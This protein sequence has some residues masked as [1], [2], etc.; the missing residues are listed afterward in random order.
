MHWT[1]RLRTPSRCQ[2]CHQIAPCTAVWS[3]CQSR[4]GTRAPTPP[5]CCAVTKDLPIRLRHQSQPIRRTQSIPLPP[6]HE[7]RTESHHPQD[8]YGDGGMEAHDGGEGV[9]TGYRSQDVVGVLH[10]G[11]PVADGGAAGV[12]QGLGALMHTPH[13][14]PQ[15]PHTEHI[16][17]LPLHVLQNPQPCSQSTEVT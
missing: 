5:P 9:G 16:Q 6:C 7:V 14:R 13:L 8:N 17:R 10:V 12:L 2:A 11:D 1:L 15:Q 4:P 3:P